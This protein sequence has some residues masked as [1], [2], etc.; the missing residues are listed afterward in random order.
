MLSRI[1]AILGQPATATLRRSVVPLAD[2]D[3]TLRVTLRY[4]PQHVQ[5]AFAAACAERLYPSYAGFLAASRHDDEGLVRHV[6]D[7]AWEGARA[8]AMAEVDSN[9]CIERCVALIPRDGAKPSSRHTRTM[10]SPRRRTRCKRPPVV[11][12]ARPA[13]PLNA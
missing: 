7:L 11:T 13:G 6:L 9:A 3:A 12:T 8:Q 1:R 10:R 4:L 5:A 2:Y